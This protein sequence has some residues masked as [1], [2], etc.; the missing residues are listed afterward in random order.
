MGN[1]LILDHFFMSRTQLFELGQGQPLQIQMMI[2]LDRGRFR[3]LLAR[4]RSIE[5]WQGGDLVR[6]PL[7]SWIIFLLLNGGKLSGLNGIC[8]CLFVEC[9]LKS[10]ANLP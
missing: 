3:L 5:T 4:W 7:R 10:E 6:F 2:L 8:H 1:V 9:L